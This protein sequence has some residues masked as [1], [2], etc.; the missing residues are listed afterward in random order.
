MNSLE[1]LTEFLTEKWLLEKINNLPKGKSCAIIALNKTQL[2]LLKLILKPLLKSHQ[3]ENGL[4]DLF[5]GHKSI[6][7]NRITLTSIDYVKGFE[8]FST[9]IPIPYT[10]EFDQ[11][12]KA[13]VYTAITRATDDLTIFLIKE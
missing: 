4:I 13:R 10:D 7:P 8:F 1:Q 2:S 9:I 3:N 11:F 6:Q 5:D 12:Q